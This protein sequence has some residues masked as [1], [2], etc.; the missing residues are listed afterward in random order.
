VSDRIISNAAIVAK[1][2]TVVPAPLRA[3]ASLIQ[4]RRRHSLFSGIVVTMAW[5]ALLGYELVR[6]VWSLL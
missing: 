3:G 4:F 2:L 5:T 6:I 1:E